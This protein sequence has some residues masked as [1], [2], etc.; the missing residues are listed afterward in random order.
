MVWPR[1]QKARR[2]ATMFKGLLLTT[3]FYHLG[4]SLLRFH[5]RFPTSQTEP[6]ARKHTQSTGL[7]QMCMIQ[8]IIIYSNNDDTRLQKSLYFLWVLLIVVFKLMAIRAC[9]SCLMIGPN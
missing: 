5:S 1:E 6:P 9:A 3:Y 4:P 8:T 7:W 2:K